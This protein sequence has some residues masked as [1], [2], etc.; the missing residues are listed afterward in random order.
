LSRLLLFNKPYLV[1]CQFSDRQGRATLAD[2][3]PVKDVYPAG[4]LDYNS[5]GLVVLT[6]DGAL[7]AAIADPRHKTPKVYWAQVEGIPDQRAISRL[8]SG[9][10]LGD[11][12]TAP[13]RARLMAEPAVWPRTPPIRF[14]KSIPTSW[15]ELT[16]TEGRNRQARRMTA[17]VGHP[18]LRLIR[19]AVGEWTLAGLAAGEWREV[20]QG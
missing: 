6:D 17:A 7:Q 14:R 8:R 3:I 10:K 13:A 20:E 9:V 2:F 11:G 1:L 19:W 5:E 15:M 12:P 18:T 16:L 4:R